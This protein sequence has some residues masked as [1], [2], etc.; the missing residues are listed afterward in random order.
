[1]C[2]NEL[3]AYKA[4]HGGCYVSSRDIPALARWVKTQRMQYYLLGQ[5]QL[6]SLTPARISRLERIGFNWTIKDGLNKRRWKQVSPLIQ[7][8][9]NK[10]VNSSVPGTKKKTL[11]QE[12]K[13]QK[14]DIAQ[15]ALKPD[16]CSSTSYWVWVIQSIYCM[17]IMSRRR[18]V[19]WQI[20][21]YQLK[22]TLPS[23]ALPFQT[24][25]CQTSKFLWKG[26]FLLYW[27]RNGNAM[28][29]KMPFLIQV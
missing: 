28:S 10:F 27:M 21:Y 1:M 18:T 15:T 7:Y 20:K 11:F 3:V 23:R 17:R 4:S 6:S 8:K 24:K 22:S 14:S 12:V 26:S 2:F 13:D 16:T 25:L 19:L 29:V 9:R 5:K